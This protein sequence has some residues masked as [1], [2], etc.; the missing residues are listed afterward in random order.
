MNAPHPDD[1]K[2]RVTVSVMVSRMKD[3]KEQ[4][5]GSKMKILMF[6]PNPPDAQVA[7][8]CETAYKDAAKEI[9]GQVK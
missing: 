9:L 7:A 4:F 5:V 3:G 8:D 1:G 6:P 2:Y